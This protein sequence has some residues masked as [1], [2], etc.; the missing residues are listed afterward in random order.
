MPTPVSSPGQPLTESTLPI[1]VLSEF[2]EESRGLC[3]NI[4]YHW[5]QLLFKR[6]FRPSLRSVWDELRLI[7]DEVLTKIN[8]PDFKEKLREAGLDGS[9]LRLKLDMINDVWARFQE[10]GLV[11]LLQDV[12]EW[13]SVYLGSLT[14][15]FPELEA[16][17]EF[18]DAIRWLISQNEKL[19]G[20]EAAL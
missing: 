17:N 19:T 9:Q 6:K 7:F 5:D 13:I 15:A 2:L 14:K 4:I 8:L 1:N 16:V 10:R 11:T 20:H 3:D 12:L 18:I